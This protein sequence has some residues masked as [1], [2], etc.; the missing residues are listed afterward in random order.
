MLLK[1]IQK[2]GC[3]CEEMQL[4][5]EACTKLV[6]CVAEKH[7][8]KGLT[9]EELKEAGR[10]G[11]EK[12]AM[13]Y[14]LSADYE[15]SSY[16]KWWVEQQMLQTIY[17]KQSPNKK[18][19]VFE[20][21]AIRIN[22]GRYPVRSVYIERLGLFSSLKK[23][24]KAIKLHVESRMLMDEDLKEEFLGYLLTEIALDCRAEEQECFSCSYTAGG[25]FNDRNMMDVRGKFHGRPQ[26][27]VR[28]KE[29]DVVEVLDYDSVV[30]C[31]VAGT[32]ISTDV[33]EDIKKR[34]EAD[35][36]KRGCKDYCYELDAGDDQYT[37]YPARGDYHLHAR[38]ELVFKPT[39]P[40]SKALRE[41]LK[42]LVSARSQ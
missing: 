18:K 5:Q 16:A 34:A 10:W 37:V 23:A 31:V 35:M 4:L 27:L 25:R 9:I 42:S 1:T 6:D 22:E 19:T 8:G 24:E 40:V 26:E 2:K 32:P 14:D 12:A 33:F 29:G 41:R 30:L 17:Q 39:K 20:L 38:S 28:F 3:D 13:K 21:Q 7:L 11:I 15:F 36:V